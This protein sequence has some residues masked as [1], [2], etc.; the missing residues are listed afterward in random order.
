[1]KRLIGLVLVG[2]LSLAVRPGC[3]KKEKPAPSAADVQKT[4]DYM[5]KMQDKQQGMYKMKGQKAMPGR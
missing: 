2:L 1:V 3:P 4:Q 5:K